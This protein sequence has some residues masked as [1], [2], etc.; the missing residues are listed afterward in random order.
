VSYTRAEP[1]LFGVF[2]PLLALVVG[3]TMLVAAI[4][5]LA[6]GEWV[7]GA[8]L[9]VLALPLLALHVANARRDPADP[10][11]R[12]SAAAFDRA[13]G[14]AIYGST[15]VRAWTGAGGRI[16]EL[17]L[18]LTRLRGERQRE[19]NA[20]GAAAYRN[21]EREQAELH[22][23]LASLDSAIA[24]CEQAVREELSRARVEV[25]NSRLPAQATRELSRQ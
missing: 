19:I 22:E 24:E 2:P 11:T 6:L 18:E 13:R 8:M 23:R 14:W 12:L 20:L 17:R 9:F 16:A 7:Y 4:I 1:R 5:S 25:A 15:A 10:L 3:L 21:D